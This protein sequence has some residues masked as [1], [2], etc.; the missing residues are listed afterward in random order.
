MVPLQLLEKELP[1]T[2]YLETGGASKG[3]YK[4]KSPGARRERWEI[5]ADQR[6]GITKE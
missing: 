6:G 4:L 5:T 2:M 3:G 1:D